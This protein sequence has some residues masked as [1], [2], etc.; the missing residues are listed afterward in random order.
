MQVRILECLLVGLE[1]EFLHEIAEEGIQKLKSGQITGSD[2]ILSYCDGKLT[3]EDLSD[4]ANTFAKSYYDRTYYSDY[5][6][7]V[8]ET[9]PTLYHV[10]D[11]F[12]NASIIE[13]ILDK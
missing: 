2:I 11:N 10:E 6:E 4:L 9:A 13:V 5:S 1:G 7:A 12:K 3:E 8:G